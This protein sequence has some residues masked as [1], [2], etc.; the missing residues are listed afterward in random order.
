MLC[1]LLGCVLYV[2]RGQTANELSILNCKSAAICAAILEGDLTLQ[3]MYFIV[4]ISH[5]W[6]WL[7]RLI[8]LSSNSNDSDVCEEIVQCNIS[9]LFIHYSSFFLSIIYRKEC[10]DSVMHFAQTRVLVVLK[11]FFD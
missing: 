10:K 3:I 1:L 4:R 5:S 11:Q 9:G 7:Q 8:K 2:I 6:P